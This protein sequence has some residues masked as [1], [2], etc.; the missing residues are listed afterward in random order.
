MLTGLGRVK[1]I[2]SSEKA[3]LCDDTPALLSVLE[4]FLDQTTKQFYQARRLVW[5]TIYLGITA[6]C[7]Q[8]VVYG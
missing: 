5:N 2:F 4:T 6:K 7:S 8:K 1:V 3:A